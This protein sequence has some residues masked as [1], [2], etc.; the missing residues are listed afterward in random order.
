[1]VATPLET[2]R[3]RVGHDEMNKTM[4]WTETFKMFFNSRKGEI[5]KIL[6]AQGCREGWLQGEMFLYANPGSLQANV[7]PQKYDLVSKIKEDPMIAEIKICG[8]D[9]QSKMKGPIEHD[10]VKLAKAPS[11]QAKYFILVIDTRHLESSFGKWLI[12]FRP[13]AEEFE[14][15]QGKNFKARIWKL[16]EAINPNPPIP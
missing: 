7:E 8:G 12:D 16:K 4:N 3:L 5:D 9:Y 11:G 6:D 2:D 13:V 1:M 15:V 10:I 14:E